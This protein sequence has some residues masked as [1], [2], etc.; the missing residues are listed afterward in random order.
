MSQLILS[1]AKTGL[2][3]KSGFPVSRDDMRFL[4]QKLTGRFYC[5]PCGKVHQFDFATARACDCP[6][7]C[8]YMGEC[9]LCELARHHKRGEPQA[10]GRTWGRGS[11]HLTERRWGVGG[12]GGRPAFSVCRCDPHYE[13]DRRHRL[14]VP[15]LTTAAGSDEGALSTAHKMDFRNGGD[16]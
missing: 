16:S 5:R 11:F 4:P 15:R 10:R 1:C 6:R 9:Q 7:E 12:W 3:F 8:P 13:C 14:V 2:L